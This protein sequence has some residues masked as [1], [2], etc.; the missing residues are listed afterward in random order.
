MWTPLREEIEV[1]RKQLQ[2]PESDFKPL[3]HNTDWRKLEEKIYKTFCQLDHPRARP[4][5]LWTALKNECYVLS[6]EASPY[7]LLDKLINVK[8]IVWLMVNETVNEREKFWF[9]EGKAE[10][11]QSIISESSY[12]DELYL[13]SRKY[14][15]LVCIN[16]H[17][18]LIGSGKAVIEKLKQLE[19]PRR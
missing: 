14:E 11:I 16:H 18:A 4:V 17:D 2:I 1:I 10:A 19:P 3:P 9:Y 8:E 12:L 15:W 5:W 6:S 7:L 13:V